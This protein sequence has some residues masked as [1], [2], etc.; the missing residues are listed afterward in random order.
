MKNRITYIDTLKGMAMLMVII[1]HSVAMQFS[2]YREALDGPKEL[3]L[4]WKIIYSF[5]MPLFAFCSGLLMVKAK[6]FYTLK[7]VGNTLLKRIKSLLIP[8][9]TVGCI[10]YVING[11]W[12]DH[13]WFLIVMWECIIVHLTIGFV[14]SLIPKWSEH[15]ESILLAIIAIISLYVYNYLSSFD[16]FSILD[17]S[18]FHHLFPYYVLGIIAT[19]YKLIERVMLN[20]WCY[21]IAL[22]CFVVFTYLLTYKGYTLPLGKVTNRIIPVAAICVTTYWCNCTDF[23]NSRIYSV[24]SDIGKH[25]LELYIVHSFFLFPLYCI[26]RLSLRLCEVGGYFHGVGVF[27]YQLTVS[28]F[29]SSVVIVCSY[30][31]I[32][33]VGKSPILSQMFLGR[34]YE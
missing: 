15:I 31:V 17:F 19:R 26:G 29:A 23:I 16:I 11:Q 6:E 20:N 2:N 8:F 30:G 12:G 9:T 5:H 1:W 14:C 18:R 10:W 34:K 7:S 33:A 3:M 21:T 25:S 32:W 24:L 28:V 13:Y 22:L 27:L 4:L